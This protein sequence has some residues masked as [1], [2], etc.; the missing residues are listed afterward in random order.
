[1]SKFPSRNTPINAR[2]VAASLRK[3]SKYSVTCYAVAICGTLFT[4]EAS[5]AE[6][7]STEEWNISADKVVRYESPNS[8]VATGNV[9]LEKKEKVVQEKKDK[10][11][12]TAWDELLGEDSG[13]KEPTAEEIENAPPP[14]YETTVK[15][16]SDWMTY[17]MDLES[18][19][20]KGNVKI[21]TKDDLLTAKEGTLNLV[22]ETGKFLNA[23]VIR[24]EDSLHLEGESIEKTGLDTYRI[25]DGWAITCKLDEGETPPW[26]FSSAKTDIRPGGY[27]VLKHAMF[28]I[29]DV[30]VLYT[31]YM[32]V[33]VKNTRQTGFLF[34][35]FSY[36]SNSGFGSNIPFFL[37]ISDSM[38]ATFFPQYF[39]NRGV[40]PGLEFRYMANDDSKGVFTGSYIDDQLSDPSETEYYEDTGYTHD[41]SDRY[42]V[43]GKADYNFS[44]WQSRLDIDIASDE[45]FLDEFNTGY[46]SFDDTQARY[47]DVFGRG[48]DDDTETERTNSF[49]VLKSW[50]GQSFIGQVI[51]INEADTD[52]SD[53][54]TPLWTL[55]SAEY[56]GTVSTGVADVTLGW[57]T[58][59]VNYWREDGL[60][61]NRV[62][63]HPS[64]ST[65]IPLGQYLESRA[66]VSVRDT[67]YQVETYGEEEWDYDSTQNRF[68]ADFETEVAT[69]LERDFN[70]NGESGMPLRHQLRP[71]LKYNYLPDVDQE[72]IPYF[73]SVDSVDEE[74][75]I[76]YGID[77]LFNHVKFDQ[78][79]LDTLLDYASFTLE[80]S[81]NIS[82][83]A[84][85][86]YDDDDDTEDT[87]FSDVYAKFKWYPIQLTAFTYKAYYDVYDSEFNAHTVEASYEN[88]R[89]DFLSL[90]YSFKSS[91]DID[92]INGAFGTTIFDNWLLKG[93][94]EHSIADDETNEAKGSIT[95]QALCWSVKFQTTYSTTDTSFLVVFNLANIG[96]PLGASF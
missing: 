92:Q 49:K 35:E 26:S 17:D 79:G 38:D 65:P 62:D 46:T 70:F 56:A 95:Y 16:S 5:Y 54:D 78:T 81:Y 9:I 30:P 20:A 85:D 8:I 2:T 93:E 76:T 13:A 39:T 7:V 94:I 72:E 88:S 67:F 84:N 74:N 42:W 31:P 41:N 53:T 83:N 34:P 60:G 82:G 91:S 68:Y 3:Y 4:G 36:S 19:K 58:E 40:M 18:I 45:D 75:T 6:K 50:S 25:V 69:T 86:D 66:E 11:G 77:N 44:D 90:D 43:R 15:I 59:Y 71:Y 63:L 37:N 10:T 23:T 48:F 29:K 32:I 24:D 1:M 52:A 47:V 14:K 89:G 64:L 21:V 55:P 73:D 61:G 28:R 51:A 33:P 12:V 57:D 80:Q 96:I 22:N 87:P 27:A